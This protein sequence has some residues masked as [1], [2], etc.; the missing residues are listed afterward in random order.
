MSS[1]MVMVKILINIYIYIYTCI[2]PQLYSVLQ[3]AR[4]WQVYGID[5][6]WRRPTSPLQLQLSENKK[7]CKG[8]KKRPLPTLG[9]PG[10]AQIAEH[11]EMHERSC[12]GPQLYSVLQPAR[13]WQVY[14]IDSLW[15]RPTSPLQ[16]QLSENKK[17]CK[18]QKKRPLPTTLRK[19]RHLRYELVQYRLTR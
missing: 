9:G 14:G 7:H 1:R 16:L 4:P 10:W 2:G 12:I 15:R 8:Q 18:G 13:P 11:R 5:S 19:G 17:H 6:L 3:P